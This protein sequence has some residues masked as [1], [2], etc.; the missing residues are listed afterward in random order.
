M[1]LLLLVPHA[2]RYNNILI[3]LTFSLLCGML[4]RSRCV[5]IFLLKIYLIYIMVGTAS[6]LRHT[7][8]KMEIVVG[9]CGY[10][11]T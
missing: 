2:T 11:G 4:R 7:T 8:Q 9:I 1:N 6:R 10:I 5:Q 3:Y